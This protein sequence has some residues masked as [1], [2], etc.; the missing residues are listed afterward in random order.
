MK[1]GKKEFHNRDDIEIPLVL[2]SYQD[3]FSSFDPRDYSDRAISKDFLLE[4]KN[5]SI[6][7]KKKIKLNLFLPKNKREIS[8]E[9]KIKKRLKE[10]FG[11]HFLE[12]KQE[13]INLIFIGLGWFIVGCALTVLTAFFME[14]ETS[15]FVKVLINIAHPG[16]WFFLWEGLAMI[17][18]HSKEK[19]EDYDFNRK[20]NE[21]KISFFSS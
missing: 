18:I 13:L 20:M 8:K 14:K 11:K 15:F 3:I 4:C 12:K 2:E 7:K 21:A 10:H 16:G 5:A 19:K 6:D 17:L 9:E 1:R